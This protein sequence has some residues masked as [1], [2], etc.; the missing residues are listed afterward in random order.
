MNSSCAVHVGAG[1][2]SG[3]G[4]A[5]GPT[6]RIAPSLITSVEQINEILL[7]LERGSMSFLLDSDETDSSQLA[8]L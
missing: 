3:G 7:R 2:R 6:L 1:E 4:R 8:A 5:I